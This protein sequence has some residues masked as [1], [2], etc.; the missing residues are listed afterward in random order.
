[1]R[2]IKQ[3]DKSKSIE[4]DG[5]AVQGVKKLSARLLFLFSDGLKS[6][7]FSGILRKYTYILGNDPR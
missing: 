5:T 7:G 2:V 4:I 3:R 6:Q 1:M